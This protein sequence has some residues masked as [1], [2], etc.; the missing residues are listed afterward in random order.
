MPPSFFSGALR[1]L[2][3]V[4]PGTSSNALMASPSVPPMT[5]LASSASRSFSSCISRGTPPA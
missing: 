3:T 4:W 1:G 2:I 5:C